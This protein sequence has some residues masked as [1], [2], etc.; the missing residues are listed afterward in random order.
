MSSADPAEPAAASAAAEVRLADSL[1]RPLEALYRAGGLALVFVFV[2]LLSMIVAFLRE[3]RLSP[4]LFGVGAG[5]TLLCIVVFAAGQVYG[6]IHAR[7]LVRENE[8]LLNSVQEVAI[9]LTDTVAGLQSLMFKHSEQVAR[10]LEAVAP[11]LS[12]LPGL[13]GLAFRNAQDVNAVIVATTEGSKEIIEDVKTALVRCDAGK[14][15]DY[16]AELDQLRVQLKE[17]LSAGGAGP[18]TALATT[19]ATMAAVPQALQQY[20]EVMLAYN[21]SA[22][23]YL[24]RIEGLVSSVC[25]VPVLGAQ[26]R[27][28]GGGSVLEMVAGL[29]RRIE[30]VQEPTLALHAFLTGADPSGL[31]RSTAAF[32]ALA[33]ELRADAA[34]PPA[35]MEAPA[36]SPGA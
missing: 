9:R 25:E 19:R 1:S 18:G 22:L 15:R 3:T 17:A 6:P 33:A 32:G 7:R 2:G 36:D 34:S 21:G 30:S 12:Q 13:A 20:T 27:Q 31:E 26:L 10:A 4:W 11:L 8:E 29:R 23:S 28:R 24:S 14:L 5:I 35:A 16:V